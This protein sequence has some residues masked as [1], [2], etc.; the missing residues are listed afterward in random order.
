MSFAFN[1]VVFSVEFQGATNYKGM[2]DD[3]YFNKNWLHFSCHQACYKIR[4]QLN[5]VCC[6]ACQNLFQALGRKIDFGFKDYV[7]CVTEPRDLTNVPPVLQLW[8]LNHPWMALPW[9]NG[10]SLFRAV[11][12]D[13]NRLVQYMRTSYLPPLA[14]LVLSKKINIVTAKYMLYFVIV[15]PLLGDDGER[16]MIEA[17]S[18]LGTILYACSRSLIYSKI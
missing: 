14:C 8:Y 4:T 18:E 5:G 7:L 12:D 9:N 16:I 1:Y 15:T 2:Y 10:N 3:G 6:G 17:M 13:K 11:E